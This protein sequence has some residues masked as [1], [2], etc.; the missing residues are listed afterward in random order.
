MK[1]VSPQNILQLNWI[2]IYSSD[3]S[4]NLHM[5]LLSHATPIL[6]PLMKLKLYDV[7]QEIEA[8]FKKLIR[9]SRQVSNLCR[10]SIV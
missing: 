10:H 6:L 9:F 5:F 8:I 3:I 4:G 7:K 2:I 1:S